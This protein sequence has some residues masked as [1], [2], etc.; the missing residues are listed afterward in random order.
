[1]IPYTAIRAILLMLAAVSLYGCGQKQDY[2]PV[3]LPY[4]YQRIEIYPAEYSDADSLPASYA[5][6]ASAQVRRLPDGPGGSVMA[7]IDYPAYGATLHLTFTPVDS[8]TATEVIANRRERMALNLADNYATVSEVGPND[9]TPF[10]S[11][12]MM[13]AGRTPTPV[14]ILSVGPDMVISGAVRFASEQ[15]DADSLMPVLKAIT[16]DIEYAAS[17]LH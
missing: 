16:A 6:N 7:D 13:S 3:P 9:R 12:V 14:Q 2:T 8:I 11:T 4:G 17:N 1:M 15:A 10:V 5:V